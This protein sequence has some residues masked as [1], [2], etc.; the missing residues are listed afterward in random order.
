M[1]ICPIRGNVGVHFFAL[2]DNN[3]YYFSCHHHQSF[4]H[5]NSF[6]LPLFL[7]EIISLHLLMA[8]ALP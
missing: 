5:L 6:P 8:I 4:Q 1:D 7:L 2:F 3:Y